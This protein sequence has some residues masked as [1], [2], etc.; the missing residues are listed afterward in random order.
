MGLAV[1]RKTFILQLHMCVCVVK[2]KW[3]M[4][5]SIHHQ[6][7]PHKAIH[8][9]FAAYWMHVAYAIPTYANEQF[10]TEYSLSSQQT[11][12]IDA[13]TEMIIRHIELDNV[14]MSN[15]CWVIH[16]TLS[17]SLSAPYFNG[18]Y[19]HIPSVRKQRKNCKIQAQLIYVIKSMR[20]NEHK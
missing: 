11:F 1:I 7:Q 12:Q 14:L 6:H 13:N 16:S 19:S 18:S 2:L 17:L 3:N 8:S 15:V 20:A 5:Q 4:T 9:E 10:E